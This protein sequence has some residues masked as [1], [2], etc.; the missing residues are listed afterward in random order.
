MKTFNI[1]VYILAYVM[2]ITLTL[3]WFLSP[4]KFNSAVQTNDLI[5]LC[6]IILIGILDKNTEL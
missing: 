4:E 6:L 2:Y 1:I 3:F 5:I